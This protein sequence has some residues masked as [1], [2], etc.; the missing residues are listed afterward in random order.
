VIRTLAQTYP[1]RLICELWGYSRS[2]F[3]YRPRPRKDD[4][5]R[6]ALGKLAAEFP[7]HGSRWLTAKLRKDGWKINRKRIQ[8]LM[9]MLGLQRKTRRKGPWTTNSR[10]GFHR[11]PNLVQGLTITHPDQVWVAD[12]TYIRLRSDFVYLAIVMDA[13]TRNIRGWH[14]SKN[15]DGNL[16]QVAL[17]RALTNHRPEIHHSDQGIHYAMPEYID[18]LQ[19]V[20]AAISMTEKGAAWQNGY[21]ERVIRTIKEEEVALSEYRDFDDATE[22][23]GRFIDVV[24]THKRIH[25]SLGYLA[26][27]EFEQQWR[28]DALNNSSSSHY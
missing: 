28:A 12:I 5:L 10:H 17:T 21:A 24:Y 23:I 26:P 20:D 2:A 18:H 16:T 14:L 19:Q 3:Y 8:R 22:Q 27:A 7:T 25:S 11:Y 9:R 1:V 15:V 13:F 4:E 6:Q